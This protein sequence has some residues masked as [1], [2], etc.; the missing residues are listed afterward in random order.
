[1]PTPPCRLFID[2]AAFVALFS[3][4]DRNH[5][6]AHDYY[7][8]L[9]KKDQLFTT[10]L[11]VSETYT[12]FRYHAGF[13]AGGDFLDVIDRAVATGWLNVV[14]PDAAADAKTRQILRKHADQDISY[15]D[16]ASAAV[17]EERKIKD[18][19]TFDRHFYVLNK[20]VRPGAY[21]P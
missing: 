4:K 14:Y 8:S 21:N 19:F 18:V 1:V 5:S 11:V 17:M 3:K 16:A 10:L 6:T 2:T 12:W 7:A 20:R 9:R 13:R 15:V